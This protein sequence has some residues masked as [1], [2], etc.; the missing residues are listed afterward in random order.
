MKLPLFKLD[1]VQIIR[2]CHLPQLSLLVP[3]ALSSASGCGL[4]WISALKFLIPFVGL[5]SMVLLGFLVFLANQSEKTDALPT[6][7]PIQGTSTPLFSTRFTVLSRVEFSSLLLVRNKKPRAHQA[8]PIWLVR[9]LISLPFASFFI[10]CHVKADDDVGSGNDESE[11]GSEESDSDS[12][13]QTSSSSSDEKPK[14]KTTKK[15]KAPPK[16]QAAAKKGQETKGTKRGAP[17]KEKK[18]PPKKAKK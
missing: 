1:V 17:T 2:V 7:A 11:E 10:D 18:A 4:L 15:P 9:I 16:K 3:G 14:K 8:T 5:M 6:Y 13:V 12:S